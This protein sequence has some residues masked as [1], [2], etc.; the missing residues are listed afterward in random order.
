MCLFAFCQPQQLQCLHHGSTK[1]YF[2]SPLYSIPF[3]LTAYVT[4]YGTHIMA[5]VR[6]LGKCSASRGVSYI[7]L[8]LMFEGLEAKQSIMIHRH[9][10]FYINNWGVRFDNIVHSIFSVMAGLIVKIFSCFFLF[11][12]LH[13][14]LKMS[15]C[16]AYWLTD[17]SLIIYWE[18]TKK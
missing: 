4:I 11:I 3:S 10:H 9:T 6:D 14:G 13:N 15:E 1:A 5:S 2:C 17:F 16:K 8:C 12:T 18:H 7:I